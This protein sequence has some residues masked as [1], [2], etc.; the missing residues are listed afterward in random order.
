VEEGLD[1][2]AA[3][4]AAAV[5]VVVMSIQTLQRRA[6]QRKKNS[7]GLQRKK[8]SQRIAEET[9]FPKDL[10]NSC[11]RLDLVLN[12]WVSSCCCRKRKSF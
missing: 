4:A 3:A 12:S 2:V 5:V 10:I 6:S 11:N 7:K 9:F 8:I 1:T